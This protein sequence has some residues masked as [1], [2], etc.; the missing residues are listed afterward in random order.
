MCA[1]VRFGMFSFYYILRFFFHS[2]FH[3]SWCSSARRNQY[4]RDRNREKEWE[5]ESEREIDRGERQRAR[6][7]ETR[8]KI[9]RAIRQP[10]FS[11]L[12]IAPQ[13]IGCVCYVYCTRSHA[14]AVNVLERSIVACIFGR[15]CQFG[16]TILPSSIYCVLDVHFIHSKFMTALKMCR[17]M[18]WVRARQ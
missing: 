5:R 14:H 17:L 15:L 12:L 16:Y 7:R 6:K 3:S 4:K 13:R 1:V 11:A 9:N 8:S 10:I 2:V 18:E